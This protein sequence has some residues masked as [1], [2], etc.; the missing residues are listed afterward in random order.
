MAARVAVAMVAAC[1]F[2]ADRAHRA[3][4]LLDK[5]QQMPKI[6]LAAVLLAL[7]ACQREPAQQ[8]PA[9]AEKADAVER[10]APAAKP[11]MTAMQMYDAKQYAQCGAAFKAAAEQGGPRAGENYYSAACCFALDGKPD[12]AFAALDAGIKAG[13]HDVHIG[14]DEDLVTLRSDPRWPAVWKAVQDAYDAA[15]K[16]VKDPQLQRE[17]LALME[18]DQAARKA[19]I[20][21]M[22]VPSLQARIMEV[23]AKTTA[24]MKDV[25]AKQGWPGKSLV[26]E[27]AA[28]AAWLL[29][30]HADADR[31]FQKQCLALIEKAAESGE[32]TKSDYAYLYDRVAVAEN[33]PQ[34]YGTQYG[35]GKPHPIEDE[36]H[37]DERRK[38]VGLGTMAEY[39][40]QMRAMYGKNLDGKK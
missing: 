8:Q 32:V 16:N 20:G 21:N 7:A 11:A 28:H 13:L 12:A 3:G 2:A 15:E 27:S 36:A 1:N 24:R 4:M 31:A 38:A 26:G 33:R 39:D 29:V 25:I 30:Q 19:A 14:I 37:V 40:A 22:T 17:L 9:H 23:D 6:R 35:N 18:E 34:R 10:N 5:W